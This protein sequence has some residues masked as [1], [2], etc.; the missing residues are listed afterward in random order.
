[1]IHEENKSVNE[2]SRD[3]NVSKGVLYRIRNHF[4]IISQPD[5]F[6]NVFK[7][8][9]NEEEMVVRSVHDFLKNQVDKFNVKDVHKFVEIKLGNNYP[10]HKIWNIMK[11]QFSLSYKRINS[12][13]SN[14]E[15]SKL[16]LTRILFS[17]Y[18]SKLIDNDVLLI[19]IDET[20]LSKTTKANYSWTPAGKNGE[21]LNAKYINSMNIVLA[22]CSNGSWLEMLTNDTLNAERFLIFLQNL[23]SWLDENHNFRFKKIWILLD[24]LSS[25]RTQ[26]VIDFCSNWD[27]KL[28]FIPPYSPTWA[29]VELAFGVMKRKLSLKPQSQSINLYNYEG[30]SHLL[31]WMK[32]LNDK[33]I[34]G[35]FSYFYKEIK[36]N[37]SIMGSW[38]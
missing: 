35:C 9:L 37:I 30:Y 8:R 5:A 3:F 2:L 16:I 34:R 19:N 28:C 31:K 23:K 26:K 14:I 38:K 25:H 24:N 11:K 22:I 36:D 33:I 15:L 1:M 6:R 17:I 12:R 13:P 32:E 10:F 20:T 18:A 21:T 29:P 4:K 27:I 7:F